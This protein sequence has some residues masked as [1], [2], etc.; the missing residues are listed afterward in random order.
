[1][2]LATQNTGRGGIGSPEAKAQQDKIIR[3]LEQHD[4]VE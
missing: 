4:L 2:L 3:L 1:M